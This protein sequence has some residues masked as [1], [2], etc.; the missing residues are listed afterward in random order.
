MTPEEISK[1]TDQ[2]LN[3]LIA[4]QR[5]WVVAATEYEGGVIISKDWKRLVNGMY[6]YGS[7]DYA[8]SW[9]WAGELLDEI[10]ED[11]DSITYGLIQWHVVVNANQVKRLSLTR[12]ISEAYAI[13]ECVE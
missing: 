4:V 7:P 3:E 5:G 10:K 1:L 13:M 9:Q 12:A 2:E 11:L 6:V 8:N